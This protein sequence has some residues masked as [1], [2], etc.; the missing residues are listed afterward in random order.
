MLPVVAGEILIVLELLTLPATAV[1]VT[2]PALLTATNVVVA[3][4][5]TVDPVVL[6]RLPNVLSLKINVTGVPSGTYCPFPL[7]VAVSVAVPHTVMP[8]AG[9]IARLTLSGT[10]A[11]IVTVVDPVRLSVA[12]DAVIVTGVTRFCAFKATDARPPELVTAVA[13]DSVAAPGLST[14]KLTVTPA[15]PANPLKTAFTVVVPYVRME[16]AVVV[17]VMVGTVGGA[18]I[19]TLV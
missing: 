10:G 9:F 8:V 2:V 14:V 5:P 4:P 1:T 6:D 7:T 16:D 12:Y 19:V 15:I 3:L 17:R 18:V 13:E 11:V